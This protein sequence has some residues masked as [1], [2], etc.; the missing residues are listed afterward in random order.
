MQAGGCF[1]GSCLEYRKAR[2]RRALESQGGD[3]DFDQLA[4]RVGDIRDALVL[5]TSVRAQYMF[6]ESFGLHFG[7][8][9]FNADF[10][11]DKSSVRKEVSYGFDGVFGGISLTI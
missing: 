8:K 6:N 1:A 9:Y 7:I 11:V 10:D 2:F 3:H 5:D 4:G